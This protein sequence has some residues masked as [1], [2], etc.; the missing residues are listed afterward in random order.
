[1]SKNSLP[2]QGPTGAVIVVVFKKQ[3]TELRRIFT[4]AVEALALGWGGEEGEGAR[5]VI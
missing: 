1:M 2:T 4:A 5:G 3:K